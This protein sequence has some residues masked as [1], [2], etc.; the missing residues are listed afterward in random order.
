V[1]VDPILDGEGNYAGAVH[2]VSDITE[3]KRAEAEKEKL[4]SQLLQAVK[5]E[6]LGRLAGGIAHDFNNML[7]VILGYGE[8]ILNDL[9]E[10]D[11]LRQKIAEIVKAGK[12]SAVLTRQ[13]LAFSRRQT[14][15][16]EVLNLNASS[17][18]R[19]DRTGTGTFR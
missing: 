19:R 3:R 15:Q 16:P 18:R 7:S 4:Q 6:S 1:T 14:L 5:L 12:H 8:T 2:I 11:P 13:L 10:G 17:H 9:H